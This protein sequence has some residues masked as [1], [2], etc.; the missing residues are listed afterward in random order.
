MEVV[1]VEPTLKMHDHAVARLREALANTAA[2]ALV[3]DVCLDFFAC[4][5]PFARQFCARFGPDAWN[6]WSAH[7]RRHS[8]RENPGL[9]DTAA[10]GRFLEAMKALLA[11]TPPVWPDEAAPAVCRHAVAALRDTVAPW[12][13]QLRGPHTHARFFSAGSASLRPLCHRR[14]RPRARRRMAPRLR[15]DVR[16]ARKPCLP[17]PSRS[18]WFFGLC[19]RRWAHGRRLQLQLMDAAALLFDALPVKPST[20]Q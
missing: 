5:N 8:G 16:L 10:R 11:S 17:R 3:L 19:P 12:L 14:A 1:T 18:C 15:L 9:R 20:R 7:W 6:T 13:Q 2:G 4:H